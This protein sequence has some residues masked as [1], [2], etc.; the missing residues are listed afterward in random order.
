MST[1][2]GNGFQNSCERT[3]TIDNGFVSFNVNLTT[4]RVRRNNILNPI[5]TE[6]NIEIQGFSITRRPKTSSRFPGF[7]NNRNSFGDGTRE[8]EES[9]RQLN[10][11][12]NH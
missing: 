10:F 1:K 3:V 11:P 7:S 6:E 5:V 12:R 8:T 2:S 9:N 4:S